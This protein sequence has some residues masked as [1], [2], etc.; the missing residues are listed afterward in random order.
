M[1]LDDIKDFESFGVCFG[2][3]LIDVALG[4][5]HRRF[6]LGADQIRSVGKA[7]EVE[8]LEIHNVFLLG[9]PAFAG[10]ILGKS[11]GRKEPGLFEKIAGVSWE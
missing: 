6:A 7:I 11:P 10:I 8:L 2:D 3:E 4:I 5:D 1:R 9:L